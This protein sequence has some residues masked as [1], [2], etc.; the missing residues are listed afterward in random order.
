MTQGKGSDA[1]NLNSSSFSPLQ[2]LV[3]ALGLGAC[4]YVKACLLPKRTLRKGRF[5]KV[6]VPMEGKQA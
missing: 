6:F 4:Y 3:L 1:D 2:L 5:A